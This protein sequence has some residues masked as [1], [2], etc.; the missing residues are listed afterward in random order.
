MSRSLL[1]KWGLRGKFR[2]PSPEEVSSICST[3]LSPGQVPVLPQ[4]TLLIWM[5]WV[6]CACSFSY[7]CPALALCPIVPGS[8]LYHLCSPCDHMPRA[9]LLRPPLTFPGPPSRNPP[10]S[11][12]GW[13]ELLWPPKWIFPF[14]TQ[15]GTSLH[16]SSGKWKGA[17]PPPSH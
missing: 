10:H 4:V 5:S 2:P 14:P 16:P 12:S 13:C 8:W 11:P 6:S 7:K 1:H 3:W 17:P 9:P 15:S